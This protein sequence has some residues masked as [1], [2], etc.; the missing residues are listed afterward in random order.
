M[1]LETRIIEN[2]LFLLSPSLPYI[3][4]AFEPIRGQFSHIL[5][6]GWGYLP[7]LIQCM[8]IKWNSVP[9]MACLLRTSSIA[10][11]SSLPLCPP[12]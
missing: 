12:G 11:M 8:V 6:G 10:C 7:L 9:H 2:R 1:G 5:S 4:K 3:L